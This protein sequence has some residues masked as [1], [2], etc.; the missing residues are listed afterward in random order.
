MK[1]V[2]SPTDTMITRGTNEPAGAP[3]S[4]LS[5]ADTAPSDSE[6]PGNWAHER[7]FFHDTACFAL[8]PTSPDAR[9]YASPDTQVATIGTSVAYLGGL[10][11]R[12]GLAIQS[13]TAIQ[14]SQTIQSGLAIASPTAIQPVQS[15]QSVHPFNKAHET[16]VLTSA[17]IDM[18]TAQQANPLDTAC[19]LQR[20]VASPD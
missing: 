12:S 19:A 6:L 14:H 4:P 10:T 11:L 5:R 2:I 8:R 3:N 18:V 20:P 1:G 16:S 17:E 15:I 9:T 13:P 7:K